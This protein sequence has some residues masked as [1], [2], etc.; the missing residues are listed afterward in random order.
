LNHKEISKHNSEDCFNVVAKISHNFKEKKI[1]NQNS[2][3]D[4]DVSDVKPETKLKF[5]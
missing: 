5:S 2:I 4:D 3:D 1:S